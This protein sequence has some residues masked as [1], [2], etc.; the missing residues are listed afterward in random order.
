MAI[1]RAHLENRAVLKVTGAEREDFLQN[2]VTQDVTRARAQAAASLSLQSARAIH[3]G[4]CQAA[5]QS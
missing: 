4:L 5:V 1:Y 3:P 2:L